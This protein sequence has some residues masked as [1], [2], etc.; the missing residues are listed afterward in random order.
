MLAEGRVRWAFWPPGTPPETVRQH[1]H[2]EGA[3]IWAADGDADIAAHDVA[4]YDGVHERNW[5]EAGSGTESEP[6]SDD[7]VAF[8]DEDED[9]DGGPVSPSFVAG[10]FGALEV[11]GD[12]EDVS[13]KED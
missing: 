9:D 2:D 6:E 3:G 11:S 1:Q 8:D 7:D 10:R 5:K 4:F 13:D 12:D